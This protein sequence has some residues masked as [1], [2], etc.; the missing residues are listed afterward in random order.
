GSLVPAYGGY[1]FLGFRL[2]LRLVRKARPKV[3]AS[4]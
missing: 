3:D 1:D 4:F 2:C